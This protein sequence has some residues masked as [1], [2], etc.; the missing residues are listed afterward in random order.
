[1]S[2]LINEPPHYLDG[3]ACEHC[4]KTIECIVIT[5][6]LSFC[7]GN[8]VKYIWRAGK[9]GSAVEDLKKAAWYIQRAIAGG[10]T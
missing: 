5:E 1:M 3:P 8:A 4:G 6:R 7:L 2:D 10:I 9:K